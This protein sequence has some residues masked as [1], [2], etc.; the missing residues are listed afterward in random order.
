MMIGSECR[1]KA[2]LLPLRRRCGIRWEPWLLL[3]QVLNWWWCLHFANGALR[4]EIFT[5]RLTILYYERKIKIVVQ[6]YI[7]RHI[8]S[9]ILRN[10][11]HILIIE[12]DFSIKTFTLSV[13]Y[14][15]C[16]WESSYKEHQCI[17]SDVQC[18]V[19]KKYIVV[20]FSFGQ[21][22]YVF[23]CVW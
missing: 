23:L 21:Q 1:K 10:N 12:N 8:C 14:L 11:F 5:L 19:A 7:S 13:Q 18:C 4:F 17:N 3:W 20:W 16:C 2:L 22:Y 9:S 6:R 15:S